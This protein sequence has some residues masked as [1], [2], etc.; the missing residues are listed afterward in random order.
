MSMRYDVQE[1]V[2]QTWIKQ[3]DEHGEQLIE[4]ILDNVKLDL[5]AYLYADDVTFEADALAFVRDEFLTLRQFI[6]QRAA[7]ET[8]LQTG[9]PRQ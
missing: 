8:A 6:A 3:L 7:E 5:A 9:A 1:A 4:K 2:R